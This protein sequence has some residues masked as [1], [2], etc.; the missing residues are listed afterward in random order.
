MMPIAFLTMLP[1][2][3]AS[4][5]AVALETFLLSRLGEV[6]LADKQ[7]AFL[8]RAAGDNCQPAAVQPDQLAACVGM[9]ERTLRRRCLD[10][11]GYGFKTLDRVLRFQRFLSLGTHSFK[12]TLARSLR[13]R[14][15]PTRLT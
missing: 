5:I 3:A 7:I 8:R 10:A 6:G 1:G 12:A 14:A 13:A 9:S 2:F 15:M 4:G 11:F